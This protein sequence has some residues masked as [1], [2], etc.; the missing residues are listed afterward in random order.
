MNELMSRQNLILLAED[1]SMDALVIRQSLVKHAVE[2]TMLIMQD[3]QEA[4]DYVDRTEDDE[5]E[6]VPDLLLLDL[7]LPKRDGREILARVRQNA[8]SYNTPV[9]IV[10]SSD[11]REDRNMARDLGATEYFLK[12]QNLEEYMKL[13]GIVKRILSQRSSL[14]PLR[15]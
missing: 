2:H 14:Q 8:R 9:V 4:I 13:G 6:T 10:T 15:R 7:N 11:S 1:N 12:G 3:G 5:T